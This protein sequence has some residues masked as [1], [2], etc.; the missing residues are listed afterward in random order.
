MAHH[1]PTD[2]NLLDRRI[3]RIVAASGLLDLTLRDAALTPAPP[4]SAPPPD[5]QA[6]LVAG[7]A[8]LNRNPARLFSAIDG[9]D[10]P[11]FITA[12]AGLFAETGGDQP[13]LRALALERF[14]EAAT[15]DFK[16]FDVVLGRTC[17]ARD[18]ARLGFLL[19]PELEA[20]TPVTVTAAGDVHPALSPSKWVF[21]TLRTDAAAHLQPLWQLLRSI[22]SSDFDPV[23]LQ[24]AVFQLKAALRER[25]AQVEATLEAK[26]QEISE[27]ET[28]W[29]IRIGRVEALW[30]E[31]FRRFEAEREDLIHRHDA[32]QTAQEN[33]ME[34]EWTARLNQV[35]TEYDVHI[36]NLEADRDERLRHLEADRDGRIARLE[37]DRDERMSQLQAELDEQFRQLER[38]RKN[39]IEQIEND[40]ALSLAQHQAE[41]GKLGSRL[42]AL[43]AEVEDLRRK[44]EFAEAALRETLHSKSWRMTAPLRSVMNM[45]RGE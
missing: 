6:A 34:A 32:E 10:D 21:V 13:P 45:M 26:K 25:Q 14:A 22:S 38:E 16:N 37:A 36:R 19:E 44:H 3:L 40:R 41:A 31:R 4:T 2:L 24:Y 39:R 17:A 7:A 18:F 27:L 20:G 15:D 12:H 35:T 9:E 29:E 23:E 28:N 8:A 33:R 1:G 30:N 11:A 42:Q 43:Q 5:G